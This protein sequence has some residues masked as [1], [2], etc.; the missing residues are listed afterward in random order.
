MDT[1]SGNHV[2]LFVNS[3]VVEGR[4]GTDAVTAATGDLVFTVSAAANG[5]VTLDQLRAVV[6][7]DATN[8]D[9]SKS[10]TA[11]N[12][13]T[14]DRNHH[15]QGRRQP[16]RGAQHRSEPGVQGRWAEH[17]RD[18]HGADADGGRDGAGN[19]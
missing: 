2:F 6:H 3:G 11:D 5:D 18:G 10:L 4:A 16:E 15:R 8:P 17:Q 14:L 12:L 19:R 13:V 9:D 1:A 7:P